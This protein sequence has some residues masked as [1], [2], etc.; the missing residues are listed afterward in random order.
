MCTLR[1]VINYSLEK[2]DEQS[3]FE[4]SRRQKNGQL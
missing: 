1:A 3:K 2:A 4:S